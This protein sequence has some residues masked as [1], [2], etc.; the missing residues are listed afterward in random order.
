FKYAP[1]FQKGNRIVN[2]FSIL[3]NK[4]DSIIQKYA[5]NEYLEEY[6]NYDK[7]K[8]N[9]SCIV[10][11]MGELYLNNG[12]SLKQ[13]RGKCMDRLIEVVNDTESYYI[14]ITDKNVAMELICNLIMNIGNKIKL[15]DIEY[16]QQIMDFIISKK[17]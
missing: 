16:F 4:C 7:C 15:E 10:I 1:E 11:F 17:S 3:L 12:L 14:D 8:N 9:L 5:N 6:E 2:T 13:M